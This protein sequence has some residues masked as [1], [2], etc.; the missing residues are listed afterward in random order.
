MLLSGA[1]LTNENNFHKTNHRDGKIYGGTG[2][3]VK[4]Q[5]KQQLTTISLMY[6]EI[7]ITIS[8]GYFLPHV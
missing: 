6:F 4:N 8:S 2:I 5:L 7:S 1:H 3:L